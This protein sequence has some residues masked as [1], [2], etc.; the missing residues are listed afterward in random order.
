V[1]RTKR[2]SITF[3]VEMS[4]TTPRSVFAYVDHENGKKNEKIKENRKIKTND[5]ARKF[6]IYSIRRNICDK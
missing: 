3:S 2:A 4:N 6:E 5:P 1:S